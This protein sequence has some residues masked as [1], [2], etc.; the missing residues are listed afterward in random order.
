V[1]AAQEAA[2][3]PRAGG[4]LRVG[5]HATMKNFDPHKAPNQPEYWTDQL[6]YDYLLMLDQ[7][8]LIQ[9]A[10]ATEWDVSDDGLTWTFQLRDG[11]RFHNG[12]DLTA[13]DVKYSF[14]RIMDPETASAQASNFSVVKAVEAP[15][16]QTVVI[17]LASPNVVLPS[18]L[19]DP[20]SA[21]VAKEIVEATGD[22]SQTDAGSGPFT[23][24]GLGADGSATLVRNDDYWQENRPYVDRVVLQPIPE[25][26]TRNTALRTGDVDMVTFVTANFI[27]LLRQDPNVVI[28]ELAT[29]GQYY[30]LLMN[31]AEEPFSDLKV[32][33]AIFHALDRNVITQVS[34]AGEG[35]PLL[36]AAIPP[37]HW[38]AAEPVY[39]APNLDQA[40]QLLSESSQPDGFEFTLRVWS[41]Q[42]YAQ[43][44]AQLIQE[45]LAPL[46]IKP[47]IELQADWATYW[48]PVQDGKFQA[49]IQGTGGNT[50]PDVWLYEPFHTG[51]SK[52]YTNYSN[53]EVDK[54]LDEGRQTADQEERK[55]IYQEAQAIIAT[56]GPMAFLYNMNQTEAWQSYVKGFYHVPTMNLQ[57]LTQTWL[58]R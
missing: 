49:T 52:N 24:D 46:N 27:S 43:R 55:R 25:S 10:L 56:D 54:L 50:D 42:D 40:K 29:S 16:P 13:D 12:R 39:T 48:T 1:T 53:P 4:D 22:L 58:K 37:W 11:V 44:S 41:P 32:R 30:Y 14:A 17:H 57:A 28:P 34:L 5:V 8:L 51:G 47:N 21:I 31:S 3:T 23:F 6:M 7:D 35:V 45:Q 9:P 33:Q 38:A 20:R 19:A 2:A 26:A 18:I 15:D 36:A